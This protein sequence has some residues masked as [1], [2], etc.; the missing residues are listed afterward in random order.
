[1]RRIVHGVAGTVAAVLI[2]VIAVF[3]WCQ[4]TPWPGA[5]AI[6]AVFTHGADQRAEKL[7]AHTPAGVAVTKDVEYRSG[8]DL[9]V[10]QSAHKSAK[11]RPIVIWVHGGAWL[12]GDKADDAV[13]FELLAKG[14][15][16]VAAPNYSL[17]PD[18][19]YPSP[20][21]DLNAAFDYVSKNAATFNADPTKIF[22][23]GDSAGSNLSAQMAAI[24]TNP[25]YAREVGITPTL[26]PDQL[27]GV[28]LTC[29]IYKMESLAEPGADLPA[30]LNWGDETTVWAYTGK[31][32]FDGP[33]IR[34]MSPF[35]HVN[36][37]FPPAFI[38]G[39]NADPLTDGQS[40]PFAD[41]LTKLG[42]SVTKLFYPKDHEP[43]LPHEYQF[44]LD[45]ADGQNAL[46]EILAFLAANSV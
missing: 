14:G 31:E 24:I 34:Q 43:K 7:K 25:D 40:I 23:A 39:G 28:V 13:Y 1:M 10:Y 3:V 21:H 6:R 20:L 30:I 32:E 12:S 37:N 36:A 2:V 46:K 42:V 17:A 9:D 26:R 5:M 8:M 4:F 18:S 29:G 27:A 38:T 41:E 33:L 15:Y 22:L 35:Y 45:N 44:N 19:H 16:V 11:P